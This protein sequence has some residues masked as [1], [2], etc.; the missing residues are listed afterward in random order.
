MKQYPRQ[1]PKIP[2]HFLEKL[3]LISVLKMAREID[4]KGMIFFV[5]RVKSHIKK[6]ILWHFVFS[7]S[8]FS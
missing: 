1:I 8:R 6:L 5:L 7:Q 2:R 3:V 4:Q